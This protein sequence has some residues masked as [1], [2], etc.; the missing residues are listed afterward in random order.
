VPVEPSMS[1]FAAVAIV[2]SSLAV[3]TVVLATV[4]LC[5]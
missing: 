2:V 4:T 3:S 1:V 5:S